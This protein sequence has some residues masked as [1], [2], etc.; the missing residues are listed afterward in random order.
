MREATG[1]RVVGQYPGADEAEALALYVRRYA[2]LRATVLLFETRLGTDL[3]PKEIDA[4]LEHLAAELAEPAAVGDLDG[5]RAHLERLRALAA[6]RK[7]AA[8]AERAAAKAQAVEA[9]THLVEAAEK[10]AETDPSR[11]QW[12]PAGEELRVAAGPVEGRPAQ[13]PAH[14][15]ADGGRALEAVQPRPVELRP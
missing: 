5:L 7:A 9:R 8:E 1:E 2:D 11:M 15:P 12:R 4:T 10:I 6:E 3:A 13:R 14:R